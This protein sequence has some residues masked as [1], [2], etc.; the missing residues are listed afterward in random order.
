MEKL[1]LGRPDPRTSGKHLWRCRPLGHLRRHNLSKTARSHRDST[2]C[3]DEHIDII[4]CECY[5]VTLALSMALHEYCSTVLEVRRGMPATRVIRIDDEVW[6]EL[7]RRARPLE[8]TPN[9]VL[10]RIIGLPDTKGT[11]GD[12]IDARVTDLMQA[13]EGLIGQV[14]QFELTDLGY[15]MF[16]QA[17]KAV[18]YIRLRKGRMRIGALEEDARNAGLSEWDGEYEQSRMFE[19]PSVRWYVTDGDAAAMARVAAALATLWRGGPPPEAG[20]PR[21]EP[22]ARAA[23]SPGVSPIDAIGSEAGN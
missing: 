8:D 1:V 2:L 5:F 3:K 11:A 21:P 9:S 23:A 19:E 7:Q 20:V 6:A 18:A 15:A 13:V 12:K 4:G 10:R 14:P 17:E 22:A 16:S